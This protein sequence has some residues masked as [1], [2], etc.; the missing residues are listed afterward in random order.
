MAIY[1]ASISIESLRGILW[2]L[3]GLFIIAAVL[4]SGTRM[5]QR[6]VEYVISRIRARRSRKD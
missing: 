4:T 5:L 3:L 6:A 1:D 2:S